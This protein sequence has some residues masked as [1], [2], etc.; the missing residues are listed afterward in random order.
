MSLYYLGILIFI[1]LTELDNKLHGEITTK[2]PFSY[3]L[4]VIAIIGFT[5][6]FILGILGI[7]DWFFTIFV[8][9]IPYVIVSR[10]IMKNFENLKIVKS[11]QFNW[12]YS[13]LFIT[14]SSNGLIGL[15]FPLGDIILIIKCGAIIGGT[16]LMVYA[17][18]SLPDLS[19]LNWM[20]KMQQLLIIHS[21]TSSLLYK[22]YFKTSEKGEEGVDSDLAESAIGGID[23][24][25]GE[26]LADSGHIKEIDHGNKRIY[27]VHGKFTISIL[28]ST[29]ASTEFQYRLEMFHLTFEKRFNEELSD[30]SGDISSFKNVEQIIRE[31]F[32]S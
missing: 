26:I 10:E 18:K 29:G 15:Y 1:F 21:E 27:F 31:Y 19:E 11:S 3:L 4:T 2:K 16:I 13:G 30:F 14:G 28:I 17:W 24:L 12:F 6:F 22:Y 9:L 23:M 25:L 7:Y 5:I 20:Q 8:I 32:I